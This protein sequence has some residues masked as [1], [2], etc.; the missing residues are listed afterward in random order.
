MQQLKRKPV[1]ELCRDLR[2]N[3]TPAE[4]LLWQLLRNRKLD[5]YKFI[6]QHPLMIFSYNR[7]QRFYIADFYCAEKKLV[8]EADG[9]VHNERQEY[10]A[11][12]DEVISELEIKTLRFKNDRVLND[13]EQ[14]LLEILDV[15]EF[16]R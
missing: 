7:R 12:R 8:I 3:Q 14:V 16:G 1:F 15:L 10:D 6:R 11:N 4:R 13:S 2:K 5:N 9:P